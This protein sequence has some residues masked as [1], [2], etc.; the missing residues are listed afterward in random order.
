MFLRQG[1]ADIY[2]LP[3]FLEN[4]GVDQTVISS[5]SLVVNKAM[6]NETFSDETDCDFVETGFIPNAVDLSFCLSSSPLM[7]EV[8]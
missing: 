7:G 5:L 8:G 1:L 2:K 6:L 3:V 4:A